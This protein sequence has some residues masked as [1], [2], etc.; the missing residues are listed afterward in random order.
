MWLFHIYSCFCMSDMNLFYNR[1][2]AAGH[3]LIKS[4]YFADCFSKNNSAKYHYFAVPRT[5]F[6]SPEE[7]MPSEEWTYLTQNRNHF[8]FQCK[9]E[10]SCKIPLSPEHMNSNAI[11]TLLGL[12][13]IPLCLYHI[14]GNIIHTPPVHTAPW[15]TWAIIGIAIFTWFGFLWSAFIEAWE[16]NFLKLHGTLLPFNKTRYCFSVAMLMVS[17]FAHVLLILLILYWLLF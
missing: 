9:Q 3:N 7:L 6:D 17:N 10:P 8:I 5:F 2:S 12:L 11:I 16:M 14:V 1:L 13:F 15:L 4:N